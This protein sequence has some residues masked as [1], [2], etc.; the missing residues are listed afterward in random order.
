MVIDIGGLLV[1]GITFGRSQNTN[2]KFERAGIQTFQALLFPDRLFRNI[3]ELN[4]YSLILNLIYPFQLIDF[5]FISSGLR[6]LVGKT[7]EVYSVDMRQE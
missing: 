2:R 6:R 1:G 7:I 4:S 3:V 5:L